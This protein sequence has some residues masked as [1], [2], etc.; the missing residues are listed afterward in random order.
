MACVP[1]APLRSPA[2]PLF[3]P[4][5]ACFPH[6]CVNEAFSNG[7]VLPTEDA[8]LMA[9]PLNVPLMASP[10]YAPLSAVGYKIKGE[11][12]GGDAPC[13]HLVYVHCTLLNVLQ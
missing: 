6:E 3:A 12:G 5:V 13:E 4:L 2:F 10:L 9:S 7:A 11:G 1:P 8:P